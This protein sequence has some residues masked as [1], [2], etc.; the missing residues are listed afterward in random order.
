MFAGIWARIAGMNLFEFSAVKTFS[1]TIAIF[2]T[3]L[4][5][6]SFGV[7]GLTEHVANKD[8]FKN[9]YWHVCRR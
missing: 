3:V 5:E 1:G 7:A 9:R 2:A 4:G 8:G 6:T